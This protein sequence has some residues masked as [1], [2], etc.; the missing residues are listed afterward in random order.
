MQT[1]RRVLLLSFR[2]FDLRG[3]G[4]LLG[5]P[6]HDP[7]HQML[8]CAGNK[9]IEESRGM[10][11]PIFEIVNHAGGNTEKCTACGIDPLVADPHGHDSFGDEKYLVILFMRMRAGTGAVGRD[12]PLGNAVT[13]RSLGA[14]GLKH[15]THRPAVITSAA[16][17]RQDD[18]G[19]IH[20][21]GIFRAGGEGRLGDFPLGRVHALLRTPRSHPGSY[22]SA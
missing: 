17:R 16:A 20:V 11:G 12:R 4:R 8:K 5:K 21:S 6:V 7:R 10:L 14:I 2:R 13:S 19:G 18:G 9:Y 1:R 3:A 15:G 22:F